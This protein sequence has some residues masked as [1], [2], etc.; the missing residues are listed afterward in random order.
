ML[1]IPS[2]DVLLNLFASA[3][4]MLGLLALALG[5]GAFV[6]RRS[7]VGGAA[8]RPTS[9]WPFLVSVGLLLSVSCGFLLYHLHCQDLQN[10]RLRTNLVRKSVEGAKGVGDTSL[11][12]LSFSG[13]MKHPRGIATDAL[14]AAIAEGRAL[15]L[16]DVREP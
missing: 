13:Q 6:R 8:V 9:R 5:G 15:N 16:I 4:Q 1:A 7:T 14:Q 11:K 10:Q 2:P 12:T 3:G